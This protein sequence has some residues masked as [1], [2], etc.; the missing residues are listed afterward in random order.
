[1]LIVHTA[2]SI[3]LLK[4]KPNYSDD[5]QIAYSKKYRKDLKTRPFVKRNQCCPSRANIHVHTGIFVIEKRIH[6]NAMRRQ[7]TLKFKITSWTQ[8]GAKNN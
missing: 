5:W 4:S 6:A 2:L 1:M 3:I 8:I 7:I